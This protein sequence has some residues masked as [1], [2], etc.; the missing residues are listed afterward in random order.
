M[1]AHKPVES[2]ELYCDQFP[3]YML[4]YLCWNEDTMSNKLHSLIVVCDVKRMWRYN[5]TLPEVYVNYIVGQE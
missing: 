1:R 3:V 2:W 4:F 5:L